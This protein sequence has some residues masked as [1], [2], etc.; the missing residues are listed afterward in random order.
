M[1]EKIYEEFVKKDWNIDYTK[2][3]LEYYERCFEFIK[4]IV[5]NPREP[6]EDLKE[7]KELIEELE[8]EIR[9]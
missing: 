8:N 1:E 9:G 2:E 7:I 5:N 4:E 3:Y 6:K